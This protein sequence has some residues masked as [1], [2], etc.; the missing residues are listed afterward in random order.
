MTSVIR[1]SAI[2]EG[3]LRHRRFLPRAHE[4]TYNTRLFYLDLDELP[5]LFEGLCLWSDNKKTPGQFKRS[6]YLGDP[7]IPLKE[8]VRE[9]VTRLQGYCPNGPV[10]MLTNLRI[11]GFCFNPVTL[12]YIF[13]PGTSAPACILAQ[14]NNTPWNQRHTYLV[15]CDPDS[16][17]ANTRFAKEFHVSP[18]NP[19]E[20]DYVWASTNPDK[21]LLVHMENHREGSCHMDATLNLTRHEWQPKILRRILWTTPWQS[22]KIPLAIYWQALRLQIKRTPFYGHREPQT[23][24]LR[25]SEETNTKLN[26]VK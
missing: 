15:P 5:N 13:E 4:F 10:R 18:F 22:L 20:M 8:S 19:M 2:Y 17:K 14:V 25:N 23:Q 7:D 3:W 12:Y 11:W 24:T 26:K 21:N 9:E 16:G 6:D 1:Y